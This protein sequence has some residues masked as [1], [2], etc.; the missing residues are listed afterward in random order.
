MLSQST[1]SGGNS[2]ARRSG[3]PETSRWIKLSIR[4]GRK[5]L[6]AGIP[7]L[8]Y[9]VRI[10]SCVNPL[11]TALERSFDTGPAVGLAAIDNAIDS[12]LDRR[13]YRTLIAPCTATHGRPTHAGNFDS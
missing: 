6:V 2:L 1:H 13:I 11:Q 9:P 5:T 10:L 8:P 7:F 4:K 3:S 12:A